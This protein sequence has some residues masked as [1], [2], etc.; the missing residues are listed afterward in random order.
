DLA[1]ILGVKPKLFKYFFT[2]PRL[3]WHLFFGPC[4]PYQYRLNGLC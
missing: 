1:S 3:W 2:D 4:V